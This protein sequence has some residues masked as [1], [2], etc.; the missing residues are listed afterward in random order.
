MNFIY[1]D[2]KKELLGKLLFGFSF[3]ILCLMVILL[4]KKPFLAIDEWFTLG[5]V[6]LSLPSSIDITIIDVHPP[7]YYLIIKFLMKFLTVFNIPF[8][9]IIIMKFT[10]M[11][12]YIILFIFSLTKLKKDYGLF[13]SGLFI[14][15]ILTMSNFFTYYLTGRMYTWSLLFVLLS[16]VYIKDLIKYHSLKYWILLSVF[17]VLS[18]YTH[19]F[20]AITSI[21]IYLM[22]FGYLL[23]NNKSEIKKFCFS[24]FLNV[25]LYVPWIF[26]LYNQ[27]SKVHK[28]Y[29]MSNIDFNQLIDGFSCYLLSSD[30][31]LSIVSIILLVILTLILFKKYHDSKDLDDF[32]VLFCV[33]VFSLTVIVTIFISVTFKPL[34]AT[35]FLLPAAAVLWLGVSIALSRME[36]NK[37]LVLITLIVI[38]IG[39][40]SI[41]N[42]TTNIA[43]MYDDTLNQQELLDSINN[44]DTII[45]FDG[46]QKYIRFYGSLNNTEQYYVYSIDH[47][48]NHPEYVYKIGLKEKKFKIPKDCIKNKDKEI[49]MIAD[50]SMVDSHVNKLNATVVGNIKH[51]YILNIT[52]T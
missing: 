5:L 4:F 45:I 33:L 27:A 22:L 11:I 19:Y 31:F 34:L 24:C 29:W 18:A 49:Y 9:K 37:C 44:N 26:V 8:E 17:S 7:L 36:F 30:L 32:Y 10:S 2:D 20:A 40:F 48:N 15:S 21:V 16:F 50:D 25:V 35:R 43:N 47:K 1:N 46:M 28:S 39:C 38:I 14:F 12:P 6:N 23:F 42:Q 13:A 52:S 3:A 51:C 41:I